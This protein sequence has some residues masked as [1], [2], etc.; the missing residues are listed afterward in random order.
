MKHGQN[1]FS[2]LHSTS[3]SAPSSKPISKPKKLPLIP[4]FALALTLLLTACGGNDTAADMRLVKTDG[5]VRVDNSQGN[6]IKVTKNL[7]LYSGYELTTRTESY[8]WITLDNTKLAKMDESSNVAIRRKKKELELYVESGG[9]FFNVTEPL[10][11]D[12]TMDIRTSTMSVGIRGTCGWVEVAGPDLMCVY[13]L[14]GKVECTVYDQKGKPLATETITAGQAAKMMR[15]GD[16]ATII[17][18]DFRTNGTPDFVTD[19]L[20]FPDNWSLRNSSGTDGGTLFD[21]DLNMF[22]GDSE[23]GQDY[24]DY[25]DDEELCDPICGGVPY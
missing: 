15:D 11:E 17:V 13:L 19:A 23:N 25:Y 22:G 21:N 12:E 8:G 9:L 5:T 10:D 7:S 2:A 18:A 14:R 6:S 4:A 24:Y 3:S 20:T 16:E 1:P